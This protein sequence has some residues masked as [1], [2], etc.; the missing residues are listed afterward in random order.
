[1]AGRGRGRPRR[2]VLALD[3]RGQGQVKAKRSDREGLDLNNILDTKRPKKPK[4]LDGAADVSPG[5]DEDSA[6]TKKRVGKEK[7]KAHFD[8][9]LE[10][11]GC[12]DIESDQ[13]LPDSPL[14]DLTDPYLFDAKPLELP[15]SY[16]SKHR[17]KSGTAAKK[18]A[19][20]GLDAPE[21]EG[22]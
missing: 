2:D 7:K 22:K 6:A 8:S 5:S 21:P 12:T 1:M 13:D 4:K 16:V 17:A 14:S 15:E 10:Y 3:T 11:I 19:K 20:A 9:D 18:A